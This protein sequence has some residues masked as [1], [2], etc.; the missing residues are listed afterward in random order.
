MF[1]IE[2]K[3]SGCP[4]IIQLNLTQYLDLFASPDGAII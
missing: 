3:P 2:K 4:K 1:L